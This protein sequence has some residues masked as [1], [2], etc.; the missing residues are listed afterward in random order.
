[1]S[2]QTP[3]ET[4]HPLV[5]V[6]LRPRRVFRELGDAPVGVVDYLLAAAQGVLGSLALSQALSAGL[7]ES[8]EWIIAKA[9]LAGPVGGVLG[10]F[11]MAA[12]YRKLSPL[13][14]GRSSRNQVIHV[15]AYGTV[16]MAVSLGL[17]LLTAL[18][19]GN[20]AF[21][22]TPPADLEPFLALVLHAHW[23]AN[24]LL[25][26]WSVILQVM[27]FSEVEGIETR[28]AFGILVLGQLILIVV[29][30]LLFVA[31]GTILVV[32]FGVNLP[33]APN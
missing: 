6:W 18:L 1:M 29:S 5:D 20:L 25:F 9:L 14:G 33:A 28:R 3:T 15:L 32:A 26:L 13:A 22:D 2:D 8:A 10:I 12:L 11:L 23:A 7:T 24:L 19:A 27:G 31:V 21:V 4:I 16:P 17:W 30:V